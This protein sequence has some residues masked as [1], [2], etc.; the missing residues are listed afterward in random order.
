MSSGS[1][2]FVGGQIPD[3]PL[4]PIQPKRDPAA[5]DSSVGA[6]RARQV[7]L[8]LQRV[9]SL[10]TLGPVAT[11][12]MTIAADDEAELD[13]IVRLIESDPALTG[14]IL[15]LCSRA[16]LGVARNITTVRRAVVM[17]G[18]EAVQS[19]ALSVSVYGL[20]EH[21]ASERDE[22]SSDAAGI[23]PEA[24]DRV[25][26][27]RYCIAVATAAEL[28]AEKHAGKRLAA[29]K[30]APRGTL[31]ELFAVSHD[32]A[33]CAGL[34]HGV[35]K[36]VLQLVLP[37]SYGRVLGQAS[38]RRSETAPIERTLIGVDH[39]T[40]GKRI[41]EHWGLQASLRDVM[42]LHGQPMA[43]VPELPHRDLIGVVT[44]ARALC[45]ELRCGWSGEF[46]VPPSSRNA[47][48]DAG[49]DPDLVESC[50][51]EIYARLA[52]RAEALGIDTPST[53]SMLLEAL[54][55]ANKQLGR[56]NARLETQARAARSSADVLAAVRDFH[57]SL[58][59]TE[60]QP[61]HAD[62]D[63]TV[64]GTLGGVVR[65]ASRMLGDGF[66]LCLYQQ[67]AGEAWNV[68][69][70]DRDG[71]L[72]RSQAA[73]PPPNGHGD[74]T[75]L[76][77]LASPVGLSVQSLSALPWLSDFLAGAEDIRSVR[78][79]P[80][81]HDRRTPVSSESQPTAVLM[82][83]RDLGGST[84]NGVRLDALRATWGGAVM[85]A[86][87]QEEARALGEQLADRN[88]ALAEAQ[89]RLT[90]TESLARL[91]EMTAGAAHEMNNPL[92]VISG[93]SQLLKTRLKDEATRSAAKA[94]HVAAQDL[95]DLVTSLHLIAAPPEPK[96]EPL[97][98]GPVLHAAVEL[99][100]DRVATGSGQST[101]GGA[102]MIRTSPELAPGLP[103]VMADREL[104][105][106][107]LAEL[108]ANASEADP[109]GPVVLRAQATAKD[110]RVAISVIDRGPGMTPR[111]R[112]HA[113]DPFFS[114]KPAGR[115]RGLGLARTK[116]L[117]EL[118]D[119]S[120][121]LDPAASDASGEEQGTRATVWLNAQAAQTDPV[122]SKQSTPP[123][124]NRVA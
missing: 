35:G 122:T 12:L 33:F 2:I 3:E 94:I 39:H 86:A 97:A 9:E 42:W 56:G 75:D 8:I 53:E 87:R 47:A 15:S 90:E 95:T 81:T 80:L 121:A 23:P 113:F 124:E 103:M 107:A 85:A 79:L 18:L 11:R 41:S 78:M 38:H 52:T 115:Q 106:M 45:L 74:P 104:L 50:G 58:H 119:G 123:A 5:D 116:R 59:G 92:T 77:E 76:A 63:R 14:R 66:Y 6:R 64:A 68:H 24:F 83:D 84:L 44:T 13:E 7:D 82:H 16:D 25:G 17:L 71:R 10:P 31:G 20:L 98:V 96:L 54:A 30:N 91:G 120:I 67:A 36:L 55:A 100:R 110:D 22:P 102:V 93:R 105:T 73:E 62:A 48:L 88:R 65:S 111:I 112:K 60:E 19:A 28:I 37:K 114:E 32:E 29:P 26:Y 70:F 69:Q 117:V 89:S 57:A 21:E 4:D 1:D 61:G 51:E 101:M 118:M 27:W 46:A 72:I 109:A 43:S 34:L 49:L 108:I 40:A 99:A